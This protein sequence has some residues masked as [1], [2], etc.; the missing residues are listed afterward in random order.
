M[1]SL[2]LTQNSWLN[3][4]FEQDLPVKF[5]LSHGQFLMSDNLWFPRTI[6]WQYE[7]ELMNHPNTCCIWAGGSRMFCATYPTYLF[8]FIFW[9]SCLYVIIKLCV[10]SM[11]LFASFPVKFVFITG[12]FHLTPAF[13]TPDS[14]RDWRDFPQ[15][16]PCLDLKSETAQCR[17]VCAAL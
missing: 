7:I 3:I 9:K 11:H 2:R 6:L 12:S 17:S 1:Q 14:C 16:Q 13:P 10:I 5:F 8:T 15:A 4:L